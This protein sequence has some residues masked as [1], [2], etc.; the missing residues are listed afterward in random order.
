MIYFEIS[1]RVLAMEECT[2][3]KICKTKGTIYRYY[4]I[5]AFLGKRKY[6]MFGYSY[7]MLG[8]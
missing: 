3:A 6:R 8:F 2:N 5:L 1:V 7:A 4:F